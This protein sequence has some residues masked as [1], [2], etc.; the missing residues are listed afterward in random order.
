[1]TID[2]AIGQLSISSAAFAQGGDIPQQYTCKGGGDNPP[3]QIDNIPADTQSLALIMDDP[4]APKGLFTHWLVWDIATANTIAENSNPGI[5]GTN[6][7]GK[8]GYHP[9]CPPNGRHR[10]YFKLYALDTAL[11]LPA[12]VER[13][14]L[15]NAMQGHIVAEG[16]LMGYFG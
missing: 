1:M 16:G 4:D 11:D 8:T 14:T 13:S 5:S 12:G 7:A 6:S 10:Y 9:P 3:L 2:T 15:E